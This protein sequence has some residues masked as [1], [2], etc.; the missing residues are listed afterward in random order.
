M[1]PRHASP[2]TRAGIILAGMSRSLLRRVWNAIKPPPAPPPRRRLNRSQRRLL[3]VTAI[4]IA[5]GVSTWGVYAYIASAPDRAGSHFQQG[6]R[7]LGPGDF[8]GAVAQ[9]SAAIEIWPGYADAY[10]GRGKAET[11]LGQNDVALADF[12]K[13]LALN[14][15]LEQA[16]T[17]R[18]M[19]WRSRGDFP[20]ALADFTQSIDI[21][22]R[23]DAYYQRGLIYQEEGQS[24]LALNDYDLAIGRDPAVPYF[25][26]AR[27]NAKRDLGDAAGARGDQEKAEQVEKGQ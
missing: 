5:L 7:L 22:P 13:A 6:M 8:R 15:T 27:A 20:K 10:I 23:A 18:G 14:P 4:A 9:F 17:Y 1:L 11:A 21:Q 16:Y 3:R 2:G 26:R 12:E 24:R 25:Y 19:V